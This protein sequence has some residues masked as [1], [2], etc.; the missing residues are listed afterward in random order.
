MKENENQNELV[1]LQDRRL[2]MLRTKKMR[3]GEG[4]EKQASIHSVNLLTAKTHQ[5]VYTQVH[6]CY[7]HDSSP[8]LYTSMLT[9]MMS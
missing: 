3:I 8:Y 6:Y 4:E 7:L 5:Q 9:M 1:L 2:R